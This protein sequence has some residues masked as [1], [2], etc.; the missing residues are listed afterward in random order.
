MEIVE[1]VVPITVVLF[2]RM[3]LL[4]AAMALL[5]HRNAKRRIVTNAEHKPK[6]RL[7]KNN[8]S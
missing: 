1:D 2:A 3:E 7:I 8:T 6:R 5:L 4:H